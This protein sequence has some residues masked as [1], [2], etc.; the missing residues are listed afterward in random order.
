M[1]KTGPGQSGTRWDNGQPL[2]PGL[3]R[4]PDVAA[5]SSSRKPQAVEVW[6]G[7]RFPVPTGPHM[8][9]V[10]PSLTFVGAESDIREFLV[11]HRAKSTPL[12]A[13]LTAQHPGPGRTAPCAS[14]NPGPAPRASVRDGRLDVLAANRLGH[15][16]YAPCSPAGP[17]GTARSPPRSGGG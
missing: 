16:R 13:G 3:W 8:Y 14:W 1:R 10:R 9:A 12:W 2:Q 4:V 15:A 17:G 11:S 5:A 6:K 7:L